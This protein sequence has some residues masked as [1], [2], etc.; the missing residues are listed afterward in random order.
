M[1]RANAS[2]FVLAVTD[3]PIVLAMV[4]RGDRDHDIAAWF[5]V[6]PGRMKAHK[7][8]KYGTPPLAHTS[9]LPPTGA[10]GVKGRR[11]RES[12]SRALDHLANGDAAQA[13]TELSQSAANYDANE[14]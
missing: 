3:I 5:G 6:N 11:L 14:P 8:G 2:G 13:V 10:P 1:S 9:Q 4:A 12:V 7:D